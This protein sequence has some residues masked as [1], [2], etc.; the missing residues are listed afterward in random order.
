MHF[1]EGNLL[2]NSLVNYKLWVS[3]SRG[4]AW[5]CSL[6]LAWNADSIPGSGVN[7]RLLFMISILHI[8]TSALSR[9]L[10]QRFM[11]ILCDLV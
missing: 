8:E 10:V 3:R 4:R 1:K 9:I 7:I 2:L 5:V 11:S 6:S